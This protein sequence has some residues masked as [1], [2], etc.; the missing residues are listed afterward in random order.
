MLNWFYNHPLGGTERNASAKVNIS[1]NPV[2]T[3]LSSEVHVY[4]RLY[5]DARIKSIVDKR[6]AEQPV[7]D[8][9]VLKA[10]NAIVAETYR[11]ETEE[12]KSEVQAARERERLELEAAKNVEELG[13]EAERT[14]EQYTA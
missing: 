11:G 14:P 4:S 8:D 5:Y 10:R 7:D 1:I 6:L 9:E 12:I 2:T 13:K 3:R